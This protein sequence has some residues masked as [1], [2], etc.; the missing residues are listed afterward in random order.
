LHIGQHLLSQCAELGATVVDGGRTDGPQDAIGHG[1]GA[2]NLQ[3]VATRGMEIRGEHALQS[4]SFIHSFFVFKM[5]LSSVFDL[6]LVD[7]IHFFVFK[8]SYGH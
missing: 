3:K 6:K 2:W 1:R 7:T 5:P 8:N 4:L